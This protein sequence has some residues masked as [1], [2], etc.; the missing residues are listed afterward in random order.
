MFLVAG[1]VRRTARVRMPK[2]PPHVAP[3]RPRR[4][5]HHLQPGLDVIAGKSAKILI[6]SRE[7]A[8]GEKNGVSTGPRSLTDD[9]DNQLHILRQATACLQLCRGNLE[10]FESFGR[11]K[12]IGASW[13]PNSGMKSDSSQIW[14]Q[15]SFRR[16]PPLAQGLSECRHAKRLSRCPKSPL[17]KDPL[18]FPRLLLLLDAVEPAGSGGSN[19][20][21]RC[22][23]IDVPPGAGYFN[24][25][26]KGAA[27]PS[28]N[29]LP[30]HQGKF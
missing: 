28:E 24:G 23:G 7:G 21:G 8:F 11:H 3:M 29:G 10:S 20:T 5:G 1:D 15:E 27:R 6:V 2:D 25:V 12:M 19:R 18:R 13:R 30:V 14:S 17:V 26:L 4:I 9:S 16:H 22:S